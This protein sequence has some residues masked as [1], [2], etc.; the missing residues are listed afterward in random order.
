[1]SAL[2]PQALAVAILRRVCADIAQPG[3]WM[4]VDLA[5][6]GSNFWAHAPALLA[7][8]EAVE[9]ALVHQTAQNELLRTKAHCPSCD[10]FGAIERASVG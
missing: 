1:M 4:R 2:A 9:A 8:V 6:L 3:A 5:T 10:C 7:H